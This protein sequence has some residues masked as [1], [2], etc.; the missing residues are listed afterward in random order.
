MR[1]G[2]FGASGHAREVGDIALALGFAP[3]L[4]ARDETDQRKAMSNGFTV[5]LERDLGQLD[6]A[7][8]AIG[9]GDPSR[10]AEIAARYGATLPFVNLV[11]PSATFGHG[12]RER[13][14]ACRGLV[15]AAGVRLTSGTACGDFVHANLNATVSHDC[16]LEDHVTLAPGATIAGNV[17][18]ERMCW[19][20]ANA[21]VLQGS[22]EGRRRIGEG[23]VVGA[24]AV[25]TRDCDAHAVYVGVPA[26]R[27]R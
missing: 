16:I 1:V 25:V 8:Y 13:L 7:A 15:I 18:L 27:L 26:R 2:I 24:G 20:G 22:P 11:H 6:E 14:D 17:H 23:T 21:T 10:R 3:F 12:Q 9:V 4:I 19:I 5:T